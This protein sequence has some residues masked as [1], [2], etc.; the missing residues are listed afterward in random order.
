MTDPITRRA[1]EK[2][3]TSKH[4]IVPLN[5]IYEALVSEGLMS[6][7]NLDMF[8]YLLAS[9]PRFEIV[10]GL[11]DL[12]I[13][14]QVLQTQLELQG[15]WSGPLV[16]LRSRAFEPQ[17]LIQ[18]ILNHLHEMNAALET[19]WQLRPADDPEIEA[20]LISMLMMGDMLEREIK[21]ALHLNGSSEEVPVRQAHNLGDA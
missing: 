20:E 7:T 21:G 10:K 1:A 2:L 17:A 19:A 15:F 3:A 18:D 14:S 5:D 16:M 6:R 9:D 4:I 11:E 8:E 12:D 13:L